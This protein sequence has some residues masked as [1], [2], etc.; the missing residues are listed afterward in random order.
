MATANKL[1][2]RA[3]EESGYKSS[4]IPLESEDIRI[5]F[6]VI[7]D[8][9]SE[10][11]PLYHLGFAPLADD[12]DEVRIPRAADSAVIYALAVRLC[13]V[14]KI[15]VPISL[16]SNADTSMR[17]MLTSVIT[18]GDVEYPDT[19]PTGSGNNCDSTYL[20]DRFF[21]ENSTKNF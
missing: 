7:N 9:L 2:S 3:Y 6:D 19:L 4:E 18:I 10:W 21:P 17:N 13:S 16:A 14:N 12:S 15:P 8:M 1:I 5:G 20:D 11:E